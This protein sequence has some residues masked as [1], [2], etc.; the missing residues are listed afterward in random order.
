[1]TTRSS[2]NPLSSPSTRF[3]SLRPPPTRS[4]NNSNGQIPSHILAQRKNCLSVA[5][6]PLRGTPTSRGDLNSSAPSSSSPNQSSNDS[7]QGPSKTN[8]SKAAFLALNPS[9]NSRPSILSTPNQYSLNKPKTKPFL[10]HSSLKAAE[11]SKGVKIILRPSSTLQLTIAS[12]S[13]QVSPFFP[14]LDTSEKKKSADDINFSRLR[15]A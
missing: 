7:R 1:M 15:R 11:R 14:N 3:Q 8:D 4:L 2:G 9:L 13:L 6:C 10:V 12:L 5:N